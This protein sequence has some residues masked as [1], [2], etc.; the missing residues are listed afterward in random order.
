MPYWCSVVYRCLKWLEK[1]RFMALLVC[2]V[3]WKCLLIVTLKVASFGVSW[4]IDLSESSY[5]S[6]CWVGLFAWL[7]LVALLVFRFLGP[8][9][10][11]QPGASVAPQAAPTLWDFPAAQVGGRQ[12]FTMLTTFEDSTLAGASNL[13]ISSCK[14]K[15]WFF[16]QNSTLGCTW[17]IPQTCLKNLKDSLS[18]R[19]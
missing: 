9:Y 14:R 3:G 13:N 19:E 8:L 10:R 17:F 1:Y 18:F 11:V 5:A 15:G 12:R 16:R 6:I 7:L 2:I 4:F